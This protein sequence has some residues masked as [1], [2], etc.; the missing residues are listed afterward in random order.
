MV[1]NNLNGVQGLKRIEAYFAEGRILEIQVSLVN[2][3]GYLQSVTLYECNE[4]G[5]KEYA[6]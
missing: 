1:E 3:D 6:L 5:K 4:R 2:T